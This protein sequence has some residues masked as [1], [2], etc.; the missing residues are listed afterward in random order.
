MVC[1]PYDLM[2]MDATDN[3][4]ENSDWIDHDDFT[5]GAK[6]EKRSLHGMRVLVIIHTN[7]VH[8]LPFHF[9]HCF[10]AQEDEYQL[11]RHGFY[12]S[13][14]KETRTVFTFSLLDEYLL[15]AVET[16]TS[17][18]HFYSKLR[19]L[20]N[21]PF[22]HVV[23]DRARELRRAG[24]Q[25]RKLKDLKRHGFGHTGLE[26]GEG[27]LALFCAAC[28]QPGVN[29]QEGWERDEDAWKYTR[30]F[31]ADGNFT[32]VHRKGRGD[33]D[34]ESLVYL[35]NGEGFMTETAAYARHLKVST[36]AKE[37]PTCH[38][39][40][41]VADKSK[42]HKGCDATGVGAV[43][44]MRHGAFAPG[45][46]VDFQ[47]GERQMNMDWALCQALRLS[48][49]DGITRAILAY[50]INCQYSKN[51]HQRIK[52]GRYLE[53][54]NGL[55]LVFG[56]GLFHVHGHL[57]GCNARYSLTFIK[58]AGVASGEILESLW[59][60]V[61]EV[62]RATST[63]TLAHRMETLDA[64]FGDSNWKKMIN[65]G[66]PLRSSHLINER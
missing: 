61:N 55:V 12:P 32:C 63:M 1:E 45:S 8:H 66:E 20:T 13:T 37:T 24:C 15:D 18:H 65:L 14:T 16:F 3:L 9:C 44:C 58:G 7:G 33:D 62:A 10:D 6:P 60:V 28:P 56:I 34:D 17:T 35:K 52:D 30:S 11:L 47:K 49:M 54:P 53:L 57:D 23:P 31:V 64:I 29:L 22:P 21:E 26:P 41:A 19:R 51:L 4:E 59:A 25:W 27:D 40:R 43:A 48:N 46:V 5:F 2:A 42:V 39:H 36:E 38:E 50:D